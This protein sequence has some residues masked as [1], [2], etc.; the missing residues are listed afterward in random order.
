[1]KRALVVLGFLLLG[2]GI[3]FAGDFTAI[4]SRSRMRP[5]VPVGIFATT[6]RTATYQVVPAD[7]ANFK[8]ITVPSGTFTITLVASSAQPI[9][10]KFITIVNYGSGVVTIARSGQN[11]NDA[12][13]S[14]V[15]A[16]ATAGAP[17]SVRIISDG[18]NY[19]ASVGFT[20]PLTTAG[21]ISYGGTS[22]QP[23]RL[24]TGTAK[25]LLTAGTT[26]AYISFPDFHYFPAVNCVN[27]VAGVA[28]STGATPAGACRAG[29]N[30]SEGYLT[31]G[32]SDTAQF[33]I[34]LP[35]D[36]DTTQNPY[37]SLQVASTETTSGRTINMQ[38]ATA[39]AK[40][41]GTTTDDVSFNTAQSLGTIT[42]NTTANQAWKA[43]LNSITMTGCT[44]GG[45]LRL[46][47]SRTT[48]TATNVRVYGLGVTIPR[49]LTVQAN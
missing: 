11:I 6:A 38:L 49:L 39:C 19:F 14:I 9:A 31:W 7:F 17:Q 20:N 25:Q 45:T 23:T 12:T 47:L 35:L 29:T 13:G 46:K 27:A 40:G 42:L 37:V 5:Q 3:V 34:G 32:A 24:P 2:V 8:T 18:V 44:A 43:T 22:G 28:W 26:P 21:D 16:P 41:D 1:M 15:L 4:G 10:G 30:N 48:D 33:H 36:W